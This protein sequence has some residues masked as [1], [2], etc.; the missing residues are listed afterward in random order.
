MMSRE[1]PKASP[2]KFQTQTLRERDGVLFGSQHAIR[3]LGLLLAF[4]L[5]T[6]VAQIKEALK[7]VWRG[8]VGWLNAIL[9]IAIFHYLRCEGGKIIKF[10][11]GDQGGFASASVYLQHPFGLHDRLPAAIRACAGYSAPS[12]PRQSLPHPWC[13]DAAVRRKRRACRLSQLNCEWP[14]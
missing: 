12:L 14:L 3:S 10:V 7:L 4:K 11:L 6:F 9:A 1:P 2:W 5:E 13:F 8:M